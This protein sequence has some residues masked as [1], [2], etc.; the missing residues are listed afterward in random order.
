MADLQTSNL[1]TST[2]ALGR[3]QS[4]LATTAA[5]TQRRWFTWV[6]LFSAATVFLGHSWLYRRYLVD[7]AYITFRFVQQWVNGN[8]LVFNVGERVEGYYNFLWIVALAPFAWAGV[9]LVLAAKVLGVGCS[10]VALLLTWR[11][12]THLGMPGIAALLMAA[13]APFAAWA[14][15]GLETMLFAMLVVIAAYLFVR[16]EEAAR[17]GWS[18]LW[19]GLLALTRPEGLLYG[20][21]AV[22]L[23]LWSLWQERRWPARRDW[24]RAA[25]LIGIVV[26]YFAWRYNYYGYLLPN[27]VYAKSMGLHPRAP[28]EGFYY[29][30]ES[31]MALGGVALIVLPVAMLLD[32]RRWHVAERYW[33]SAS[34]ALALFMLISGGDWMLFNRFAVHGLPLL[35]LAVEAGLVRLGQLWQRRW[36]LPL[37]MSVLVAFALVR[38][39]EGVLISSRVLQPSDQFGTAATY[40]A[41]QEWDTD[42]AIAVTDAGY[43]PYA[44]P[45]DVRVI[46]MV[47]LTDGHIAHLDPEFP[48]GLLGRGDA[49]GKWDPDYVLAQQPRYI[50][51]N[52][53]G[54]DAN[55]NYRTNFTGTTLLANH[56]DFV[57]NYRRIEEPGVEMLFERIE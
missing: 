29:L 8:G 39:I 33:L 40:L 21:V 51:M 31:V 37:V 57:A 17:G 2:V 15:G 50:Q 23:R 47:G 5:G 6:T 22:L 24:V 55:G 49:F 25:L 12:A 41:A 42:D 3:E 20:G 56:P 30:Y 10:L 48:G 45:L 32:Q 54:Q 14:M 1:R 19:F 35:F 11:F 27:T 36:L 4:P 38:S 46:D 53:I 52:V 16:E 34:G 28:L 9:D 7:D 26:T 43:L 13:S 44:L 18:G